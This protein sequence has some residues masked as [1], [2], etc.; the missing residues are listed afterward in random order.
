MK[1]LAY[2]LNSQI[3]KAYITKLKAEQ[4]EIITDKEEIVQEFA[5]YY[6]ILYKDEFKIDNTQIKTFLREFQL[7]KVPQEKNGDLT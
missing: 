3:K 6:E 2:K 1:I 5:K 7:P 4:G